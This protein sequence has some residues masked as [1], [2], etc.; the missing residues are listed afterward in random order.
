M[1]EFVD[2]VEDRVAV[3]IPLGNVGKLNLFLEFETV[4]NT[5]SISWRLSNVSRWATPWGPSSGQS[6]SWWSS[7][8]WYSWCAVGSSRRSRSPWVGVSRRSSRRSS[9]WQA[10]SGG[11]LGGWSVV[12][13]IVRIVG[14][15]PWRSVLG[16]S[17]RYLLLSAM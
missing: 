4:V 3:S 6:S 7:T 9:S 8:W 12:V 16:A 2:P 13:G 1:V 14:I 5:E 17:I 15:S 10:I 11:S